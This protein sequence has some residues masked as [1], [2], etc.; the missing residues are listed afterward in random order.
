MLCHFSNAN[1]FIQPCINQLNRSESNQ[2]AG[3]MLPDW[4]QGRYSPP[5]A[6]L[7]LAEIALHHPEVF[8]DVA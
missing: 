8:K 2:G 3:E 4:E 1:L 6:M 5:G 7:K